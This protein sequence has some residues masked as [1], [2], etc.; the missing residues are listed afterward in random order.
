MRIRRL[1]KW[2]VFVAI[3]VAVIVTKP[4]QHLPP[5]WDPWHPLAIDH[6]MTPVTAWK[7][8][9]LKGQPERCVQV[10]A[11]A[12]PGA[13]DYL[14]LKDYTPVESCPL[15]NVVRVH[16]TG[17]EFSA[18]FTV[19]CPF[20][21]IWLM[22][23]RQRLQPLATTHLGSRITRV[24]HYGSF[25]CRNI[26]NRENARR[27]EHATASAL[28]V[29]GFRTEDGQRVSVLRDW[30]NTDE[31]DKREFLREAHKAA[32]DYFGTVLGPDYNQPHENH[33]HLD[34]STFGVCR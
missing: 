13:I 19:T 12:P 10:L 20:S 9:Q 7:V 23:E 31:P 2:G 25:A 5:A 22:F 27:S 4:W 6:G 8:A 33:F 1:V 29:A 30:D 26:Y 28:D 14:N 21:V 11:S 16:R 15:T 34:S 18:P 17:V 3:V 24:E 32:C